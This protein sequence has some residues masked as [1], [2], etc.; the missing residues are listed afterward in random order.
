[1]ANRHCLSEINGLN[2]EPIPQALKCSSSYYKHSLLGLQLQ[3]LVRDHLK[4]HPATVGCD[5]VKA[6]VEIKSWKESD[7]WDLINEKR[8]FVVNF[9]LE[10]K[11]VISYSSL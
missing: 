2:L 5:D 8:E 10:F 11:S 9:R 6:D 7:E 1:M 3:A 4:Y